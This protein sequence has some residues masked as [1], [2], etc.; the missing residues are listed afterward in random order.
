MC[1]SLDILADRTS[2]QKQISVGSKAAFKCCKELGEAKT[3]RWQP[4]SRPL[5]KTA[6]DVPR[7]VCSKDSNS[8][9]S[10]KRM[11]ISQSC[12][13]ALEAHG[14]ERSACGVSH[15]SRSLILPTER[16]R[17]LSLMSSGTDGSD[18]LMDCSFT[19]RKLLMANEDG[20]KFLRA[21]SSVQ[22]MRFR[23]GMQNGNLAKALHGQPLTLRIIKKKGS[24]QCAIQTICKSEGV[25]PSVLIPPPA[26]IHVSS[27]L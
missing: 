15:L 12:C 4:L 23:K 27:G 16:A 5:S 14:M 25:L 7:G 20:G 21:V 6:C 11:R 24:N 10:G 1:S 13:T 26:V 17:D 8:A 3:S 2:H 18:K 9:K 19:K 22:G